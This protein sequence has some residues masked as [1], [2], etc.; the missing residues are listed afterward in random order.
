[1][2]KGTAQGTR[3][4]RQVR[5][6]L[7]RRLHQ[8]PEEERRRKSQLIWLKLTRLTVFRR[9]RLVCCYVA[10]PYEVQTWQMIEDMLAQGKR[11]AVPCVIAR[12][13][14][15]EIFEIR[16]P[17]TDLAPGSY[18]VMEPL[19]LARHPVALGAIDLVLVPG[20]GFD[21]RA[22]RLGH[23]QGYYD[24]FLSRL[25]ASVPTIGLGFDFQI[26]NRLPTAAHDHAV[27]RVLTN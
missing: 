25:P 22:H 13:R 1:M 9:A 16:D 15:L 5:Q 2:G 6:R 17:A 20:I 7:L 12:K 24:R 27:C 3:T 11:V 23:G 21:A 4:K 10:L 8:Q 26:L 14:D 19:A 18:G